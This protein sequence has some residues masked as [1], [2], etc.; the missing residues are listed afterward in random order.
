MILGDWWGAD[1]FCI[2]SKNETV[3]AFQKQKCTPEVGVFD[4][5]TNYTSSSTQFFEKHILQ[6]DDNYRAFGDLGTFN[7]TLAI[8]SLLYG[9]LYTSVFSRASNLV[10]K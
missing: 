5:C 1:E 8:C 2:D 10:A 4:D 9:L 7:S 6:M 3:L